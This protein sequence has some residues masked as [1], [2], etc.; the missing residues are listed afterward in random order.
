LVNRFIYSSFQLNP[1]MFFYEWMIL[2]IYLTNV[3]YAIRAVVEYIL[4][5]FV[6]IVSVFMLFLVS[7]IGLKCER[8]QY[9]N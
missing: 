6:Q 5:T 3:D 1:F 9:S 8:I 2:T 7:K 4:F